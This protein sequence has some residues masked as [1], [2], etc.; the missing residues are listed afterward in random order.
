MSVAPPGGFGNNPLSDKDLMIGVEFHNFD[1]QI[2][3]SS[4][5]W[6]VE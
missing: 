1:N 2:L 4:L 6:I 5:A 3:N